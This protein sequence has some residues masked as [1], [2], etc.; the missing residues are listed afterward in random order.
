MHGGTI[1]AESQI[2]AGSVFR[3][4]LPSPQGVEI[5]LANAPPAAAAI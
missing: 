2:G 1:V 5:H 3:V 4:T